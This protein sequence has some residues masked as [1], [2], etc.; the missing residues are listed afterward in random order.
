M[1]PRRLAILAIVARAGARGVSRESILQ[2][3]WPD[4]DDEHGRR[5][6]S[7]AIYMLRRDLGS[8]DAI[9]G[10]RLLTLNPSE[11][12]CDLQE[13]ERAIAERRFDAAVAQYGGP[14]LDGF[15]LPGA[16]PFSRWVDDARDALTLTFHQALERAAHDATAREDHVTAV[17]HW[18]RR[19]AGDPL[20]ARVALALME[21]LDH[22][23][24]RSGALR[25]AEIHSAMVRQELGMD[26]D[27]DVQTLAA[28]LKS[29][30][31]RDTPKSQPAASTVATSVAPTPTTDTTIVDPSST[32]ASSVN[33]RDASVSR[34]LSRRVQVGAAI[35]AALALLAFFVNRGVNP[36]RA[37]V[38]TD[39]NSGVSASQRVL[40][41]PLT[42]RTSDASFDPFGLMIAEWI[43][44]GL[45]RSGLVNVV[46]ARSMVETARELPTSGN[47][48]EVQSY[49]RQL[50][51]RLDA[52][53]VVDGTI[54]RTGDSL[55]IQVRV[56]DPTT[57]L[58][59]TIV[60]AVLVPANAATRALEPLRERVAGVLAV[61]FD[62]RIGHVGATGSEPPTYD[63]YAEYLQGVQL[64]SRDFSA[65]L[66]HF[67]RAAA[68]DTSFHQAKLWMAMAMSNTRR[69][70][71]AD[72]LFLIVER[73]RERFAPYDAA[74]L[75]YFRSG[76]VH[77]NWALS[78]A[79]AKRMQ[80]LA[81]S[82][83]HARYGVGLTSVFTLRVQDGLATLASL[84]LTAGWA[85][86][87]APR[88]LLI[89]ERAHEMMGDYKQARV[90][91]D[92]LR[93][94]DVTQ[95][96][97][98]TAALRVLARQ[99]DRA[100]LLA[101]L[102]ETVS[103]PPATRGWEPFDPGDVQHQVA[104]AAAFVGDTVLADSL[105]RASD[106]WYAAHTAPNA[107]ISTDSPS[108]T[109]LKRGRVRVL[110]ALKAYA[111]ARPIV[112]ELIAR[113]DAIPEDFGEQ[114]LIAVHLGDSASARRVATT[115]ESDTA[116]YR[117]GQPRVWAARVAT[118]LG[119]TERAIQLLNRARREGFT[120][121]Q[122]VQVDPA[123]AP[124]RS[125]PAYKAF[126]A[127]YLVTAGNQ[128]QT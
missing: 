12:R 83:S 4:A 24:D 70:R 125:L 119:E 16:A 101:L 89:R 36:T 31:R 66:P 11:F 18:R 115:L 107:S 15:T 47:N 91:A 19:A 81:P 95:A 22:T 25:H 40:V 59:R 68:I 82:A 85:R 116:S 127:P 114:G 29:R 109:V 34:V 33:I 93:A 72:S 5:L 126:M 104:L 51:A 42:N 32:N 108:S 13:F 38:S 62:T 6:L 41:L 9:E 87:W 128:D 52:G 121:L 71:E 69:Y 99:R 37:N 117:F 21:A 44:Q 67:A 111:V 8:D 105:W 10:S 79:A 88:I 98:R 39:V 100:T 94:L 14:F 55:S 80:D 106:R 64:F 53:L 74:S 28:A 23:G 76:F 96:W 118:A 113:S 54:F 50:A 84:D 60:P 124:L 35:L 49:T 46:D 20:D 1:Q 58:V 112:N 56:I 26:A 77:G 3:L 7:Q 123:F 63:A 61:L 57:G 73:S 75:D 103:L 27:S 90:L 92:S 17:A 86:E 122:D 102:T 65:A 120:R 48:E 2:L 110:M 30:P 97:Q 78:Y 45:A 43:T